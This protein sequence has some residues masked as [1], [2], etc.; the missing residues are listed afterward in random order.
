M[1][2]HQSRQ[3]YLLFLMVFLS[4]SPVPGSL[5]GV[6]GNIFF[7]SLFCLFVLI[8]TYLSS[9]FS[10]KL[11]VLIVLAL[12]FA[13][14]TALFWGELGIVFLP[15]YFLFSLV[16]FFL[17]SSDEVNRFCEISS[18]FLRVV[19]VG[20]WIGF[21]Y[22]LLGGVSLFSIENPDGRENAFFLS[23]F[24]NFFVGSFIRPAGVFDEP[25]ALSFVVC[26]ISALRHKCGLSKKITWQLLLLGLITLSFAHF[27]YI[28]F[29]ALQDRYYII[30]KKKL[31]AY[32]S[33][34][35]F[36]VFILS[37]TFESS[38]AEI[39]FSR[40]VV[41]DGRLVGDSRTDLFVSALDRIDFK[42]F[43]FG[44]D[45]DCIVRPKICE[46]NGHEPFGETPAGI[47]LMLGLFLSSPY[48]Y[49]MSLLLFSLIIERDFIA[50][51]LLLLLLQRPYV[52]VF[53]YSL[54]ILLV[55]LYRNRGRLTNSMPDNMLR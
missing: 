44:T 38:D 31:L 48:F 30:S 8:K 50:L 43:F 11:P 55:V 22:A 36:L 18:I 17:S 27:V 16:V 13:L 46:S 41:T 35:V 51:G 42:S 37:P 3:P 45:A 4:I 26:F 25:G 10:Y 24:S 52:M 33:A 32:I 53:G 34:P 20:A 1:G 5:L 29:H 9:K 47:I 39:F 40:F 7:A 54:L 15:I 19:L 14:P 2:I 28:L 12:F 23:T 6:G 21:F 49:I